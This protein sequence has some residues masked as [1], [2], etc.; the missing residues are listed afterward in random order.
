[1]KVMDKTKGAIS[2]FLV[3]ILVPM[4]TMSALF[5]DASKV[6]LGKS[7][8]ASAGDLALNTALTNYDTLLKDMYG[9]F[10]TAQD[11]QELYTKLEDYFTTCIQS[12][13]LSEA[14]A[15]SYA[16]ALLSQL[17]LAAGE[18][19]ASDLL[20]LKVVDFSANKLQDA[21]LAN[22][23]I[24]KSQI[25]NFMKY[26][27][28][29]NTGL[30]FVTS[31]QSFSSL[32]EQTDLVEKRQNYYEEEK[33]VM[34]NLKKA[35]EYINSFNNS[36]AAKPNYY[37]SMKSAIDG[38]QNTYQNNV[39]LKTIKDL[40][41]TQGYTSYYYNVRKENKSV[42]DCE[43]NITTDSVWIFSNSS[44][45]LY[46]Y[47]H[48]WDKSIGGYD[49]NTLPTEAKIKEL[50]VNFYSALNA[51]ESYKASIK[52]A[53]GE[54]D[55][56][57]LAQN[58]RSG[59]LAGYSAK[60]QSVYSTYC[61]LKNAMIWVEAYDSAG[62]T[63]ND[64]N[65]ITAQTIKNTRITANGTTKTISEFFGDVSVKFENAM[66]SFQ[67]IA[68]RYSQYSSNII[69]SGKTG[70]DGV[71]NTVAAIATQ[72]N[73]YLTELNA[74]IQNLE[75]AITY[76][77]Y[78]K[79]SVESGGALSKAKGSWSS[80][81]D[82]L[83]N[84]SMGKQDQAEIEQLG[85]YLNAEEMQNLMTRLGNVKSHLEAT[86]TQIQGYKYQDKFIG[87][88][89]SYNA[90]HDALSAKIGD[91]NLKDIALNESSINTLGTVDWFNWS[92]GNINTDW[93]NDSGQS[94][95]LTRDKLNFYT[96]LYT[97]FAGNTD[98]QGQTQ[99]KTPNESE[100]QNVY[101]NIKTKSG[102]SA[103]SDANVSSGSNVS[104]NNIVGNPDL[105]S[106]N[107]SGSTNKM[108][109][110]NTG[111]SA[112]ENTSNGLDGLLKGLLNAVSNAA[113]DLRD[114]LYVSDY[115]LSMFSYDTIENEYKKKNG[116]DTAE[117]KTLTLFPINAENNL[118]YGSEV[119]YILYGDTNAKNVKDAYTTIYGIRLAFN[120]IYAFMTAEIRDTAFAMATP[121]SAATLGVIPV[122]LIQAVII[123][124]IA[125]CESG[126]DI[127][128]LKQG[129]AV[130]LFKTSDT[131]RTSPSG[132]VEYAK[133]K[134]KE[135]LQDFSKAAVDATS[136]KLSEFLDMTDEQLNEN[137]DLY[138]DQLETHLG[139]AFDNTIGN[140]ANSAIQKLT[141]L[142]NDAIEQSYADSSVN[143]KQYI[144]D[145]LDSWIAGESGDPSDLFY[146]AK[147]EAV[148]IIKTQY[149]DSVVQALKN[150]K[151]T[152]SGTV[153]TVANNLNTTLEVIRKKVL[154][155]VTTGCDAIVNYKTQMLNEVKDS[156]SEGADSLKKTLDGK[157]DDLF[158]ET[159]TQSIANEDKTSVATL[160]AF[161]Y[162]DY[163]RLFLMIGLFSNPDAL[164]ARTADVVQV[165]MRKQ[166]EYDKFLMSNA[167]A[168]VEV[169]ATVRVEPTLLA[170]PLFADTTR[171][172]ETNRY[173]YEFQYHD[174]RGY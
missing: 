58:L 162:S 92:S 50:V 65:P 72:T 91:S 152:A 16:D 130:P 97:H 89:S 57:A 14:A 48:Y 67:P 127:S 27:S 151:D 4:L 18:G 63:D 136:Q 64:G 160:F 96:Y 133:G 129:E 167:A 124:G 79:T 174:I 9:I 29:I 66:N 94:P 7:V 172:L 134:G 166:A 25:V 41:D 138:K 53:N 75:G 37:S 99:L 154:E 132:L 111:D 131:W 169:T 173:W 153:E 12:A 114:N 46:D 110:V 35:W 119:E 80:A 118:A 32:S 115:I 26:R 98:T 56:Q 3:I 95:D 83:S 101:D 62:L 55:V 5:V 8:A 163:L 10:A 54:Y 23:A 159:N 125:C 49:K 28:P 146:I 38:Y 19:S 105:P 30:G 156:M 109:E 164:L 82:G 144:S 171:D 161:R 68:A 128:D 170:L 81:A 2:I 73:G 104:G 100:G 87:D 107:H 39:N 44:T 33:N 126:L 84:T 40:Y 117:L 88:V 76:L 71:N 116:T 78:A 34:E 113:E 6:H 149:I 21:N 22:P 155:Q 103:K 157:I 61:K 47:S 121:I 145:G 112:A 168:Y 85:T 141:T 51:M 43:G 69:S 20:N 148:N 158:G 122:P 137:L 60:T 74:A 147:R 77:G 24:L 70:T 15:Q 45:T 150:A 42:K 165:N 59:N 142:A 93:L 1:M 17:G 52:S 106:A 102:E 143:I 120:L 140:A 86:K 36:N 123:I 13:G 31:L 139:T 108:N 11:C 90:V 135:A